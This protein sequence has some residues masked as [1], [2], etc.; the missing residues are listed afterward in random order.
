MV[1]PVVHS[2]KHYVQFPIDQI[3]TGIQ[4]VINLV[5]AV[6][7]SSANLANEV[8]EGSLI[9]AIY[10][11]L[12]LQNQGTLGEAIVTVSKDPIN[13]TGPSFVQQAS[14]FTYVNKKNVLFTHQ[15]LT[16]NDGVSGP[17]FVLRNWIKIPKSKQRFG[18]GDRIDLNI[19]NVS[20]NDLNRC[21]F[22]TYKEYS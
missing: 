7:A 15:G 6:E 17:V 18:L 9:K 16:S 12:W 10:I 4:Q 3:T 11:E 13:N 14:L 19:S 5:T 2:Q 1:R 21:G 22:S 8:E 20:A